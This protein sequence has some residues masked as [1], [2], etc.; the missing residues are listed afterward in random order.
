M[1]KQKLHN[2]LL[3]DFD[4][5]EIELVG[6]DFSD[7]L[8]SMIKLRVGPL[9][10]LNDEAA[11]QALD[12]SNHFLIAMPNMMDPIFGGTVIYICE[13][14]ARGA[15]GMVINRPTDMTIAELF[16]RIDLQLE[17]IPNSHPLGQRPVLFGG[18]VQ[19]DRGFVLHAPSGDYSSSLKVTDE[20]SF[21]TSRDVLESLAAG[22]APQRLLLSIGYAGWGAG[23]LEQEILAN[24]WL[25]VPADLN[26]MFDLPVEERFD[27]AMKLLGFDPLMLASF[28]GHA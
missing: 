20:V 11:A 22:D 7:T 6:Y 21:T 1:K 24:G 16:D 2:S 9:K 18:P 17:I 15:M 19:S 27:A 4:E 26:V 12:L 10:A 28:A 13:H 3:D 25:T 8:E 14:N 23:Q 5:E